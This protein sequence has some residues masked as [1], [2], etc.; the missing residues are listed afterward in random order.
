MKPMKRHIPS[1]KD[2]RC[3]DMHLK[4]QSL[5]G[6]IGV[7]PDNDKTDV[8]R[9]TLHYRQYLR[10]TMIGQKIV[11]QIMIVQ[12]INLTDID[13]TKLIIKILIYQF[14]HN[15]TFRLTRQ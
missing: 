12:K 2:R 13:K 5:K 4:S 1:D 3:S 10:Q 8:D 6:Q 11:R 14:F 9:T 15:A 7:L